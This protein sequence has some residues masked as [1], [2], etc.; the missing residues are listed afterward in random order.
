MYNN[1]NSPNSTHKIIGTLAP[2]VMVVYV[3]DT[4]LRTVDTT[5]NN[6]NNLMLTTLHNNDNNSNNMRQQL[7][8]ATPLPLFLARMIVSFTVKILGP[9]L[10]LLLIQDRQNH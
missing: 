6:H 4:K 3:L 2:N 7:E 8:N 10:L 9:I 5:S 1:N